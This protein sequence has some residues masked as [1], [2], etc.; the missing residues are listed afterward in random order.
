MRMN[1]SRTP[2]LEH[3]LHFDILALRSAL[4]APDAGPWLPDAAIVQQHLPALRGHSCVKLQG[5]YPV[6]PRLRLIDPELEC[7]KCRRHRFGHAISNDLP[8]V[9]NHVT[10][11]DVR[12]RDL[13]MRRLDL[14]KSG[15]DSRYEE[16]RDE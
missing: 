9:E 16:M 8:C 15:G 7:T 10:H 13:D 2:L 3:H 5:Q 11:D 14:A 4:D 6:G 1:R 12:W